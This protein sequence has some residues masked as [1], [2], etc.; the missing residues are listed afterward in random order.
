MSQADLRS[1]YLEPSTRSTAATT[2][3]N[4]PA[5]SPIS[6]SLRVIFFSSSSCVLLTRCIDA[7][8]VNL[9][10][11]KRTILIHSETNLIEA[12]KLKLEDLFAPSRSTYSTQTVKPVIGLTPS[13]K[14]RSPSPEL[15]SDP[16]LRPRRRSS[17]IA[18][19]AIDLDTPPLPTPTPPP[20]EGP[21]RPRSVAISIEPRQLTL[22]ATASQWDL[23][24]RPSAEPPKKKRKT[25]EKRSAFSNVVKGFVKEGD[26]ARYLDVEASVSKGGDDEEGEDETDEEETRMSEDDGEEPKLFLPEEEGEEEEP[27]GEARL[28]SP[29]LIPATLGQ[30]RRP[31]TPAPPPYQG[32]RTGQGMLHVEEEPAA[33]LD[34]HLHRLADAGIDSVTD[35]ALLEYAIPPH[36]TH[37]IRSL[38]FDLEAVKAAYAPRD[39]SREERM[40]AEDEDDSLEVEL[41]GLAVE[42][43]EAE[44][45]LSRIFSQG[46]FA[47]MQVCGQFN[48]GCAMVH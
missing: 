37:A 24:P 23:K 4:R 43:A 5:L 38:S 31:L 46:D 22:N 29:A 35:A 32:E 28:V 8:D 26:V 47:T 1:R 9:S 3:I 6:W 21:P 15:G 36:E 2:R 12:L 27:P 16:P 41:A 25:E 19:D 34:S 10:P 20:V 42:D 18:S 40:N 33:D 7:Y 39:R 17:S 11:D 30:H 14:P 44:A 48:L 45:A 13:A